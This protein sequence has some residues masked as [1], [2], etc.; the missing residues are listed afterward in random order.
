MNEEQEKRS[1]NH[2]TEFCWLLSMKKRDTADNWVRSWHQS[3]RDRRRLL[4]IGLSTT[5][6]ILT[7][8]E[9]FIQSLYDRLIGSEPDLE[10]R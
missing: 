6:L 7:D 1:A 9:F 3:D 8:S 10:E 5:V 4:C 2:G